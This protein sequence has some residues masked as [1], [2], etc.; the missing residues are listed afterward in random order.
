MV[1][2]VKATE[3][4]DLNQVFTPSLLGEAIKAK[5]TQSKI[6]QQDAALL[7]GVSKQTYIKIEQGS[8][9][10]K[11]TSLMKVVSALGIKISIQPWQDLDASVSSQE[12]GNDVWV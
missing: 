12:K 7:S 2:K 1:K 9:D 6:T 8:S 4:P 10:I 11:L 5:R 3:S